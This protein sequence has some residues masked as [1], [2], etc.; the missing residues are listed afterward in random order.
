MDNEIHLLLPFL[1]YIPLLYFSLLFHLQTTL[2]QSLCHVQ[3]DR[4]GVFLVSIEAGG[5]GVR[6]RHVKKR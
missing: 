5:G 1:S 2:S 3:T 6:V 4:K